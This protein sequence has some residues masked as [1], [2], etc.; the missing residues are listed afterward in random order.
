VTFQDR[1]RR[2]SPGRRARLLAAAGAAALAWASTALA[3]EA[4]A[5]ARAP[6]PQPGKASTVSEVVVT[7][8]K[9]PLP[10]AVV[11][12]IQPEIS[13]S[14]EDIAAYG[15]SSISDLLDQLAPQL[16]SDRGRG[17]EG[18]VILLNGH[19]I[20][21]FQEIRD[22]PPEAI[23]RADLLAEE[24]AL[25]YG[26]SANQR[27]INIVL[28]PT[29]RSENAEASGGAPTQG[30]NDSESAEVGVTR[31]IDSNPLN[32]NLR[33]SRQS[34]ITE[35]ERDLISLTQGQPFDLVG[36]I[37]SPI[38]GGEI[39]PALSALAGQTVTVV[40][41]PA[42]A[43][44]R[45]PT[46]ADFLA[47]AGRANT[48]DVR[49]FRT[50]VPDTQRLTAN[51][52]YSRSLPGNIKATINATFEANTSDSLRGL[53]GVSLIVPAGDP[54]SPFNRDV[55]EDRF[56]E[57]FGPLRSSADSWTG[58]LGLSLNKDALDGKWRLSLTGAYDHG[59]NRNENDEGL[60]PAAL[61]AQLA[62]RTAGLNP[63]GA[64]P[65]TLF[66]LRVQD[67]GRSTSDS[68]NLQFAASGPV[69]NV[70]AGP[71]RT[72]FKVGAS[73]SKFSSDS[74]R[75][76]VTQSADFTRTGANLQGSLD[77]PLTSRRN[78]VLGALGDLTVN[79]HV[80]L[81]Q[82]SDFGSLMTYGYGLNW[83][84]MDG[85]S[86]LVTHTH[87]QAAPTQAQLGN[88]IVRTPN[89]R[90]YDF[91]TGQTVDVT[92]VSGGNPDL[93]RDQRDVTSLRVTW[94]PWEARQLVFTG[95]FVSSHVANPITTFPAATADIEAAFPDRFVRNAL[96]RLTEVD[97]R[98]VNFASQD[99]NNLR[100]GFNWSKPIGPFVQPQR[101]GPGGIRIAG[102]PDGG[103]G[104]P[105][106]AGAPG[107]GG[108]QFSGPPGGG[109]PRGGGGG[110]GRGGGPGGPG[111]PGGGRDPRGVQEGRLTLSVY[112]TV[113]FDNR[114]LVRP[115]GPVIDFLDGG[116]MG[117]LGGQ[118][119]HEVEVNLGVTERGYG[120][121]LAA[122]WKSG[123]FVTGGAG[124]GSD[125][126]FS[127]IGKINLRL[128]ADLSQRK[129]LV[130]RWPFFEGAR[131]T[132]SVGNL[133]DQKIAVH[134]GT[135]IVPLSYQ[136][137]YVDPTGRTWR[138]GF[139]KLFH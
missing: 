129:T 112:H 109:G 23:L 45:V 99:R 8:V 104:G 35:A 79:A 24:A 139:R 21:G 28:K 1:H 132:F 68:G 51:G 96:G 58:H 17:G 125:L 118:P 63:F 90:I 107:G 136:P 39:D 95:E 40:G 16:R 130:A 38:P 54:F 67:T 72:S 62:A 47:N 33:Y 60:D 25:K 27:V 100:W 73:G 4:P 50:L 36:N 106:F 56:V 69:F 134:D 120:L 82:A 77:V 128:F 19:R 97:Y 29:Y 137:A 32:F 10:G 65:N 116:A 127:D 126:T 2:P 124:P 119:R 30:G 59:S 89:T 115:G 6:A 98:P 46:L 110:G 74:E 117:A 105:P 31:V 84:P 52:V 88:P 57:G 44:A 22:L 133:F 138:I 122:D 42:V 85:L 87:D 91:A 81:D 37:R 64:L 9:P 121:Q 92:Q 20:S 3:A 101:R 15:V 26:Y 75:L 123:T 55:Q 70:P 61:Q 93:V 113:F 111:G 48:T 94:K 66:A 14:S 53:P 12:D 11:G 114:Y 76:G 18:P 103:G 13:L 83:R 71:V 131:L 102:G 49:Q 135:G 78:K 5:A 43:A 7:A 108:F 34:S 80:A 86:V 41:V